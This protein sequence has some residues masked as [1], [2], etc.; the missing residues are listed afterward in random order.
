MRI[1]K[2]GPNCDPS[3]A[4]RRFF[5]TGLMG[6]RVGF[7]VDILVLRYLLI[8]RNENAKHCLVEGACEVRIPLAGEE[9]AS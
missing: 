9:N 3:E 8:K 4:K 7:C 1:N 6:A 5:S 2:L